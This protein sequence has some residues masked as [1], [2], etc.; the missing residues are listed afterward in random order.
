MGIEWGIDNINWPN[1]WT[2]QTANNWTLR[3][4]YFD[5]SSI[6]IKYFRIRSEYL[7]N[8]IIY[9]SSWVNTSIDMTQNINVYAVVNGIWVI[10]TGVYTVNNGNWT[11]SNDII[12]TVNNGNW[13]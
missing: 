12:Y 2:N 3:N 6:G 4:Y 11:L 8:S 7:L 9:Y 10:S 5:V 13:N 1:T